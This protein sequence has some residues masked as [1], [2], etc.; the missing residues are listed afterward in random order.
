METG[1]NFAIFILGLTILSLG[2]HSFVQG[3]VKLAMA[4]RISQLII[5]LTVVA[6]GTSAPELFLDVT[7]TVRGSVELAFGDLVGSNIANIG[8]I[9]GIAALARPLELQMR[10]LRVELPLV[11]GVS[12]FLWWMA[13][14]GQVGR[15]DG[16]IMLA[17][18]AGF[19]LLMFRSAKNESHEVQREV[20]GVTT[21]GESWK[22]STAYF[23]GGL[24]ALIGGA[25]LMV[26]AATSLAHAMGISDLVIGLTVVAVGTSLPELAIS[27]MATIRR[28]SDISVGNV[29]G[30]NIFNILFVMGLCA[31]ITPLPVRPESLQVDLP[32]MLGAVIF[33]CIFVTRNRRLGRAG[34][35]TLLAGYV[36]YLVYLWNLSQ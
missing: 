24:L 28:Q 29:L 6:F 34:G 9:L 27:V 26:L 11:V 23:I 4:I 33:V 36:M 22:K 16:I 32:V 12:A 19:L 8:L 7:A 3:A 13:S 30:S 14:D 15:I 10:L 18:F 21:N 20:E 17:A 1:I 2:A 31:T 25:Q 5:G 35:A